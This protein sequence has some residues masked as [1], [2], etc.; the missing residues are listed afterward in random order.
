MS[1]QGLNQSKVR[2]NSGENRVEY[3]HLVHKGLSLLY[4]QKILKKTNL[5]IQTIE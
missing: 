3:V 2:D 4:F 5:I 1:L